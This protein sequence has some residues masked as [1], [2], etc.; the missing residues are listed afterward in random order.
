MKL[1]FAESE[2]SDYAALYPSEYDADIK[3]LVLPVKRRGYVT[4]SE[5]VKLA[6]W[7][8]PGRNESRVLSNSCESV[9]KMTALALRSETERSRIQFSV[10]LEGIAFTTASVILHWFHSD[11]Y[12]IW[13]KYSRAAVE[14]EGCASLPEQERW[15]SFVRFCRE[16]VSR[17]PV[18]MRELDCALRKLPTRKRRN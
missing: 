12:P 2:I 8:A 10:K 1:I 9:E 6:N 16:V 17:N 15:E 3:R 5:L 11:D 18:T 4:R 7:V 14:F 13:S